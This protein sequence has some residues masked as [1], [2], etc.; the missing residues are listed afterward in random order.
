MKLTTLLTLLTLVL[1][2]PACP[3]SGGPPPPPAAAKPPPP[4]VN[5]DLE[6]KVE[7]EQQLRLQTEARLAKQ[8]S[9][10]GHWQTLTLIAIAAAGVLLII[11][12][13][14]GAKARHDAANTPQP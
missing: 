10:T 11:G 6:K 12:T 14:L 1:V 7:V 2:I 9:T 8:E 4:P 13:A 3:E 5:I